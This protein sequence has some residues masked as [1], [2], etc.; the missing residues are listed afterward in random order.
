MNEGVRDAALDKIHASAIPGEASKALAHYF[1]VL[2][3]A[4][5]RMIRIWPFHDAPAEYKALSGHGGDEDWLAV[6]PA[7]LNGRYIPWLESGGPF[8]GCDVTTHELP[9]G[10]V[11]H[12]GSHA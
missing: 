7:T 3:K 11:V 12:I 4:E 1:D 8:G 10:S 6:V 2:A 5:S 9:D